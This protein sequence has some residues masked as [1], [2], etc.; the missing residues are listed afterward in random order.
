MANYL[1][2]SAQTVIPV[3]PVCP[4]ALSENLSPQGLGFECGFVSQP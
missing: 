2:L 4:K 3:K 1:S